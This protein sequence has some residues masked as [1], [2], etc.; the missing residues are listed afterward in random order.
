MEVSARAANLARNIER[1]Q[2]MSTY[3]LNHTGLG[4]ANA[5]KL[6]NYDDKLAGQGDKLVGVPTKKW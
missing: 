6:D 4:P 5:M 1:H 3:E 2:W